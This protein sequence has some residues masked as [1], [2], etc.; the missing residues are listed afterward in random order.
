MKMIC[1]QFTEGLRYNV[2]WLQ[3]VI[4]LWEI[5]SNVLFVNVYNMNKLSIWIALKKPWDKGHHGFLNDMR[6]QPF[7]GQG[8]TPKFYETPKNQ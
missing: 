2:D 6:T 3:N 4:R 8:M 7:H 5:W 1:I